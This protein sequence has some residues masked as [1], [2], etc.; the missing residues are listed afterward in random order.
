MKT[1]ESLPAWAALP[2]SLLLILGGAIILIGALGLMRL[3][4]FY[5]RIHGPAITVT[6][7]AGC[8]LLA[9]MLYFTVLQSRLVIHEII[10]SL[11]LLLTAP[12]V[13]MLIMRAA[14][15]RDLRLSKLAAR[16]D[17]EEVY[18]FS[19]KDGNS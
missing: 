3:P 5:Q 7:G 12:V 15:Y 14:V 10:I 8:L 17:A 4:S 11:F 1:F 6:L 19:N 9:S 13:A 16:A 2:V 18:Q